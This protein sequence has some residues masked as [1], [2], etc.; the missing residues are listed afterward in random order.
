HAGN[1]RGR[2]IALSDHIPATMLLTL[3]HPAV[4]CPPVAR[5]LVVCARVVRPRTPVRP[6]DHCRDIGVGALQRKPPWVRRPASPRDRS[7]GYGRGTSWPPSASA[8]PDGAR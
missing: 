5:R 8:R 2:L 7:N 4:A 1:I 3:D 6:W